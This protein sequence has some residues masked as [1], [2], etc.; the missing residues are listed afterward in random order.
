[1][2]ALLELVVLAGIVVGTVLI[3]RWIYIGA[4]RRTQEREAAKQLLWETMAAGDRAKI[5][6]WLVIHG[7]QANRHLRSAVEQFRDQLY[8]DKN[9]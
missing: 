7:P 3:V 5:D 1:M 9:S 8:I 4:R 2:I 6:A